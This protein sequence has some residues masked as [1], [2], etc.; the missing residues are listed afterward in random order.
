MEVILRYSEQIWLMDQ[1]HI[2]A[3][4]NKLKTLTDSILKDFL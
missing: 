2:I 3:I 1:F 4:S